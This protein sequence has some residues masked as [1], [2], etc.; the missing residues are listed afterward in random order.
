[1]LR[2]SS[3]DCVVT[4]EILEQAY[5]AI[6]ESLKDERASKVKKAYQYLSEHGDKILT[7]FSTL[8][9]MGMQI[10]QMYVHFVERKED[11][12]PLGIVRFGEWF[13]SKLKNT[14]L[15]KAAPHLAPVFNF[16]SFALSRFPVWHH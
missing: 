9:N 1:M 14:C 12:D 4:V 10:V 15:K 8:F 6:C 3:Q 5:K 16:A 13:C 2:D 11:K 7:A